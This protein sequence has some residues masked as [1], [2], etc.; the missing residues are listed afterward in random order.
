MLFLFIEN[1]IPLVTVTT[2]FLSCLM[3]ITLP[4]QGEKKYLLLSSVG[5]M[6]R[7]LPVGN[8]VDVQGYSVLGTAGL[9]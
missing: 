1:S 4:W 7:F 5:G 8:G 2:N 3:A 9:S 6:L